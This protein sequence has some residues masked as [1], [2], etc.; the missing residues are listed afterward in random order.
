MFEASAD[1]AR[2][3]WELCVMAMDSRRMLSLVMELRLLVSELRHVVDEDS[4]ITL[5]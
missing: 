1:Q 2:W 4:I 5:T 3:H